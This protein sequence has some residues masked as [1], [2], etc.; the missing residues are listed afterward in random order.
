[1]NKSNT[2]KSASHWAHRLYKKSGTTLTATQ[3]KT[4]FAHRYHDRHALA[5]ESPFSALFS[6]LAEHEA[7]AGAGP[8]NA[9]LKRWQNALF[10]E[11]GLQQGTDN[12][13]KPE[14]RQ[15]P[16]VSGDLDTQ[17][18]VLN[19]YDETLDTKT[20]RLGLPK[21]QAFDYLPGQYVTL[22]VL[23]DGQ[24]HKRSYS[25]ASAPFQP[26]I[27][28]ITV[29]RDPQGGL[30]SNWLNDHLKVGDT[31]NVKGPFGK[32]GCATNTRPKLLLL[33]AG[34]GIVPIMSM[35][36]WLAHTEA[37]VDVVLLLSFRTCYD[38]I[39]NDELNLIAARHDNMKLYITL[40]QEPLAASQWRGLT[41]RVNGNMMAGLIPDLPER[42]VFLCGPGAFMADCRQCLQKLDLPAE[43]L[44][45]ESFTVNSPV[46]TEP[47]LVGN[48]PPI[49]RPASVRPVRTKTGDYRVSFAKSGKTVAADGA[50][51]LLE[52]AEKS[53]LHIGHECRAGSC[54]ECMV[55]CLEGQID[56][57][58][59]A[60]IDEFDRKK[61]WVYACCA[62]P[63]SNA[64]LDI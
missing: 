53:G 18:T 59:N 64:R 5:G 42:S 9:K 58:D 17:A 23:I 19:C 12:L 38:I 43:Q 34:S 52:L 48:Q 10:D 16:T 46:A 40:T 50:L 22:T 33:A 28:D 44:H 30:V 32:F 25:L 31:L 20:F 26:G 51:T 45:C 7:T 1:M 6:G 11:L 36:R 27:L 61:G 8:A 37:H 39:Y 62:Y 55:K 15:Y 24:A 63:A 49:P 41:G 35:L 14:G 47:E 54:G 2:K 13:V 4:Y 56:M 60:E 57:T 29:K 3:G 21:G